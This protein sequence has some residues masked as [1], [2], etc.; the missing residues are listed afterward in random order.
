VGAACGRVGD[1]GDVRVQRAGEFGEKG[2]TGSEDVDTKRALAY[3]P[4]A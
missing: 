1:D 4:C 3:P 2:D